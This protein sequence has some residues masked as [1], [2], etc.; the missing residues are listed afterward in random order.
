[1]KSSPETKSGPTSGP[2]EFDCSALSI[3]EL[4]A[5]KGKLRVSICIPARDEA[6]TLGDV[7]A[8]LRVPHLIESGGSGLV[9]EIVVVDDGSLDNTA[10]VAQAS[11]AKVVTL[12]TGEGKGRAM[13]AGLKASCGDVVVFLDADVLNTTPE[14]VVKLVAPLLTTPEIVLVK[15]FYVRP[16]NGSPSGGGRVTEL[17]AR[18]LIELLFPHLRSIRQPLAGETAGRREALAK[19]EFADGYGVEIALLI[20]TASKFGPGAIAQVDLGTRIHRNR[21]LDELRPQALEILTAALARSD[22]KLPDQRG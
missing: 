12:A 2:I 11:G 10:E 6:A 15:G 9:D 13:R 3:D 1:M 5:L 21:P 18:P 22:V 14:F 8:A 17:L 16:F 4:V 20:D 19:L 7:V